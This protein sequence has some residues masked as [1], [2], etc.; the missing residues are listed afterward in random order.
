M[1]LAWARATPA[2][3]T[4]LRVVGGLAS[5][6]PFNN[7][8]LP[9]WTR[10]LPKLS[11]GRY[12]AEIVPAAERASAARNCSAWCAWAPRPSAPCWSVFHRPK[13]PS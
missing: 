6:N 10:E 5:L 4:K 7:H 8:E 3:P 2:A 1:T 12:S 11:G 13:T 9:F